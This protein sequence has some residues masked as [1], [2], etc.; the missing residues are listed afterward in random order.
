[1]EAKDSS[2]SKTE[3]NEDTK[4]KEGSAE[5][6]T[7]KYAK[8]H[9]V[10]EFE[11]NAKKEIRANLLK[12][13]TAEFSNDHIRASHLSLLTN[14]ELKKLQERVDATIDEKQCHVRNSMAYWNNWMLLDCAIKF[15][16]PGNPYKDLVK[17]WMQA[18]Y[19]TYNSK[20]FVQIIQHKGIPLEELKEYISQAL[21]LPDAGV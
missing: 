5:S 6:V 19:R 12:A 3:G 2:I 9:Q 7:K 4:G 1:M 16:A 8:D 11:E 18:D 14:E 21:L 20:A 13:V 17:A 15:T 10:G